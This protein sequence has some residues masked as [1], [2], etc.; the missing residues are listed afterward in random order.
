[1]IYWK[2]KVGSGGLNVTRLT[3]EQLH[4]KNVNALL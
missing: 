4:D 1:M 2:E 3:V